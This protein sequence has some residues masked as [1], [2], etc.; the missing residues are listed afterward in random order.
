MSTIAQAITAQLLATQGVTSL[1][2]QAIYPEYDREADHGYPLAVYKMESVTAQM[3]ASG[4]TGLESADY[5]IAAIGKSYADA[6]AVGRAIKTAL[7]GSR[8]TWSG[9]AVQGVF[10]KDDGIAEDF[11]NDASSDEIAFYTQT[12]TFQVWYAAS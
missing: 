9:V 1:I 3:S 6:D 2:G 11:T 7:D 5:V 8:G 10:L 12:L 4:P